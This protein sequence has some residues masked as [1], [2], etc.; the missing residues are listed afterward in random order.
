MSKGRWKPKPEPPDYTP[1][2]PLLRLAQLFE[3][4]SAIDQCAAQAKGQIAAELRTIDTLIARGRK[5][6]AP[7]APPRAA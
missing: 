6:A 2:S 3:D 1:G 4:A 7:A 5:D